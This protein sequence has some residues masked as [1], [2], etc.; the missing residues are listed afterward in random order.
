MVIVTEPL[1]VSSK[2]TGSSSTVYRGERCGDESEPVLVILDDE[3]PAPLPPRKGA[4]CGEEI[5]AR[6]LPLPEVYG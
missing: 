1:S 2:E 3:D 6:G 4:P 5:G